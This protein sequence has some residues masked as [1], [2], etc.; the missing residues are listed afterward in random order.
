VL[1]RIY[2]ATFSRNYSSEALA[3][4]TSPRNLSYSVTAIVSIITTWLLIVRPCTAMQ[5]TNMRKS[6]TFVFGTIN[7]GSEEEVSAYKPFK[8]SASNQPLVFVQR[9][10]TNELI[11]TCSPIPDRLVPSGDGGSPPE[12][13]RAPETSSSMNYHKRHRSSEGYHKANA[14]SNHGSQGH[15]HSK[16]LSKGSAK[17]SHASG[18][19]VKSFSKGKKQTTVGKAS[20]AK[21][22]KKSSKKTLA[23]SKYKHGH[24]A[25]K[26]KSQK[27]KKSKGKGK[28]GSKDAPKSMELNSH[29]VRHHT[30]TH[31]HSTEHHK[32]S[33]GKSGFK[34]K[35]SKG[36]AKSD[37]KKS[38]GKGKKA[39][40]K[41]KF[42]KWEDFHHRTQ[43]FTGHHHHHRSTVQKSS[44]KKSSSAFSY[45]YGNKEKSS[46]NKSSS[47]ATQK[48]SSSFSYGYGNKEKSSGNKSSSGTT[49][50]SSSSFSY[51][52]KSSGHKSSSGTKKSS[53]SFSYGYG[54]T[55]KSSGNKS[56]SGTTHKSSGSFSYRYGN[57]GGTHK[58]SSSFSYGYGNKGGTKKSSSSFS[59]GYGKTDKSFSNKSSSGTKKSTISGTNFAPKSSEGF[60][61]DINSFATEITCKDSTSTKATFSMTV[62][63]KV[64]SDSSG[65]KEDELLFLEAEMLVSAAKTIS[66][67]SN[68]RYRITGVKSSS[69]PEVIG[70]CKSYSGSDRCYEAQDSLIVTVDGNDVTQDDIKMASKEV[71]SQLKSDAKSGLY[72]HGSIIE[73][74]IHG[75]STTG[76]HQNNSEGRTV[77]VVAAV[78]SREQNTSQASTVGVPFALIAGLAVLG[79][80]L[81]AAALF[82]M[83]KKEDNKETKELDDLAQAYYEE[84][85]RFSKFGKW[86]VISLS[87]DGRTL[88]S[89]VID[90][91]IKPIDA[92]ANVHVCSS[93]MCTE[94]NRR[95]NRSQRVQFI[96]FQTD[97][98]FDASNHD[99][100][101]KTF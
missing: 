1:A 7:D 97:H 61:P 69:P 66:C 93:A 26:G 90:P 21:S 56:S 100:E 35:L 6:P 74:K 79:V 57:K 24:K 2:S 38:S 29:H 86:D 11:A 40:L 73:V 67:S 44:T 77:P 88:T 14:Q 16:H 78:S 4:M 58:S 53:S 75:S 9:R 18:G 99:E 87:S 41:R 65:S 12:H 89:S 10:R 92:A 80:A 42:S 13:N 52:H 31:H 30:P 43:K 50:K 17:S 46:S 28:K 37:K 85:D 76:E 84:D 51:I 81:L 70:K 39:S 71:T 8:H 101:E 27:E 20:K 23:S 60:C 5:A 82:A 33:K 63:Y 15:T 48:S 72:N 54:K 34:G 94:C 32:S 91:S 55:D 62:F 96:P 59:Y 25:S 83:R 68:D 22:S 95:K 3:K 98:L 36:K 64:V 19:R 47:G 45:G 49:L